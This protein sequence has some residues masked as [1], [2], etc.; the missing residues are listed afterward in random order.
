MSDIEYDNERDRH[1]YGFDVGNIVDGVVTKDEETGRY[2]I[3]DEDGIGFDVLLA[4]KS[5][6][7]EK[8]RVTMISFK[9]MIDLGDIYDASENASVL[10]GQE[11]KV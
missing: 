9:S 5:L 11:K 1:S 7:G 10:T 2:V 8:V 3:V 4:L 6:V